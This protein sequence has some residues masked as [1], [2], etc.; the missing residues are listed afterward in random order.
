MNRRRVVTAAV[1]LVLGAGLGACEREQ[2]KTGNPGQGPQS[3]GVKT[4]TNP[5]QSAQTSTT[6]GSSKYP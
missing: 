3:P 1:A 6:Q 4:G 2:A 5:A